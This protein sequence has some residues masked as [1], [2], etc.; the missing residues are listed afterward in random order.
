MELGLSQTDDRA[1]PGTPELPD[2]DRL[3]L[4]WGCRAGSVTESRSGPARHPHGCDGAW[5]KRVVCVWRGR[6][7]VAGAEVS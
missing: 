6:A 3:G 4:L 7:A 5:H 1:R 2:F